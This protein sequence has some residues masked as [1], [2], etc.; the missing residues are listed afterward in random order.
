[1]INCL[2]LP[3]TERGV[4]DA[5]FWELGNGNVLAKP[6]QAGHPSREAEVDVVLKGGGASWGAV[7]G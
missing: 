3:G 5:G 1:M 2:S 7:L 4:H 6:G